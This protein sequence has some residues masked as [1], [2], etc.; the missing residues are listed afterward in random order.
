MQYLFWAIATIFPAFVLA[1]EDNRLIKQ[2]LKFIN[3][4][5][6]LQLLAEGNSIEGVNDRDGLID[7]ELVSFFPSDIDT[8]RLLLVSC[9]EDLKSKIENLDQRQ[10]RYGI[11]FVDVKGNLR[12]KGVARIAT[13]VPKK[14]TSAKVFYS[15]MEAPIEKGGMG[16]LKAKY[17]EDYSEALK[18][19]LHLVFENQLIFPGCLQKESRK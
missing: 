1:N 14:L 5:F 17:I 8:A 12:E 19:T 6:H 9:V 11:S 4:K 10:L 3:E 7:M 18:E 13:L 15:T 2:H 16:K